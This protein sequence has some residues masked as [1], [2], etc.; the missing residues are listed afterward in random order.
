MEFMGFHKKW[1]R[2][3]KACLV[4]SIASV[5]IN[6]RPRQEFSLQRGLRQGDP[7]VPF[8]FIMVMEGL[9]VAME[10]PIN[11]GLFRVIS[12][13]ANNIMISHLFYTD[14]TLFLG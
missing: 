9:H 4:S 7:M 2:W 12:V 10:D 14:D 13:G 5:L 1:L 11:Q 8:L 6:G 3:V